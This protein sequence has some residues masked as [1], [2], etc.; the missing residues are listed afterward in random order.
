MKGAASLK[1]IS[2]LRN[3]AISWEIRATTLVHWTLHKTSGFVLA[4]LHDGSHSQTAQLHQLYKF[5]SCF[6]YS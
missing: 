5:H 1:H 6:S 4:V 3:Q 2:R